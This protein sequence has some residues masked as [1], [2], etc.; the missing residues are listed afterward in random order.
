MR[1]SELWLSIAPSVKEGLGCS[2]VEGR[3]TR[4]SEWLA[5]ASSVKVFEGVISFVGGMGC[6]RVEGKSPVR[7]F[8]HQFSKST[9]EARKRT[10]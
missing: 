9:S 7:L 4:D 1:D 10:Q 8:W 6:S 3:V 2:T 5:I